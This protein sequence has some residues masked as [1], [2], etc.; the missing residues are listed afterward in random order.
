MSKYKEIDDLEG[1][2]DKMDSDLQRKYLKWLKLSNWYLKNEKTFR[3]ERYAKYSPGDVITVNFGFNVG[4]EFGGR[5]FAVVVED[6]ARKAGT[7]M[8]IPLS[9]CSSEEEVK[10]PSVYLGVIKHLNFPGTSEKH[11][12][13]VINQIRSI[14]KLRISTP[15]RPTE[16]K[17]NI[18]SDLL[19]KIYANMEEKYTG[20][21]PENKEPKIVKPN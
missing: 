1:I 4:A 2:I 17:L 7:V 3:P 11:S 14:S 9:S 15:V 21:Y 13:A 19:E 8:A 12:F 16:E 5:H 18:G 10:S 20:E 6:N